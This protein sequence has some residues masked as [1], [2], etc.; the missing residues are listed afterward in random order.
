VETVREAVMSG[1][2]VGL[3]MLK[4][5]EPGVGYVFYVAVSRA[6]RGMGVARLLLRDAL[7]RFKAN[8]MVEVFA[9]VEGDN[10]PSEKLFAAEGFVRTNLVEVS[11]EHGA[12]RALNMY[13]MMV[14]VPGESLLHRSLR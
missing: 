13:R 9:S 6:R 7:T 14:V 4:T 2:P 11:R 12:L 1:E 8:G 3:I 10:L 5:I